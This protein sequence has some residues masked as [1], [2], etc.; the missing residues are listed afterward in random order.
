MAGEHGRHLVCYAEALRWSVA[1]TRRFPHI[2]VCADA[3][4]GVGLDD[5]GLEDSDGNR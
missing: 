4:F 2:D 3:H 1:A 5:I